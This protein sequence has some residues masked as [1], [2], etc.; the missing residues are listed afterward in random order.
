MSFSGGVSL[1]R[2]WLEA[3]IFMRLRV[4]N[5]GEQVAGEGWAKKQISPLGCSQ[6]REQLQSK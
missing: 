5:A 1:P 2:D 4:L 6:V 3:V